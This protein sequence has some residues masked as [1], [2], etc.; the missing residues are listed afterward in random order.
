MKPLDALF[1]AYL[2]RSAG[3]RVKVGSRVVDVGG[4]N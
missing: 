3:H 1:D 2:G 4:Q